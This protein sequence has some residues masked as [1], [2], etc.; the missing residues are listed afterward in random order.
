[1]A[2]HQIDLQQVLS[3][4][5]QSF[6]QIQSL[7]GEI[8]AINTK[9]DFLYTD[10]MAK[11]QQIVNLLS[12][13]RQLSDEVRRASASSSMSGGRDDVELID[14]KATNPKKFARTLSSPFRSCAKAVRAY[15]NASKPGFRKYLR[16]VEAQTEVIDSQLLSGFRWEFKEAASD[17]LY[18]ILLLHTTDDAQQL[19]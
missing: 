3:Q 18:D 6:D 17:A 19:V 5:L 4:L 8:A 10:R 1:M 16:R 15:C 9:I 14:M 2:S 11:D 13:N 12:D 7:I